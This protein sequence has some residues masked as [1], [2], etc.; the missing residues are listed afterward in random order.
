MTAG[1]RLLAICLFAWL[2]ALAWLAP[3]A[4]A[5]PPRPAE[6]SVVGG[7]GWHADNRFSLVWAPPPAVFPPILTARYRTRD[8]QGALLGEGSVSSDSNGAGVLV[9]PAVPGT[10]S[11]ELRFEDAAGELGP[12]ASVPL[13]FDHARPGAT[14]VGPVPA[15]VGRTALPLRVQL[16]HPTGPSPLSGIRGYAASVGPNPGGVPCPLSDVCSEQETTLHG[17][18]A[19]D[20]LTIPSLPEGTSY[21]HVVAVSGAG[22]KSLTTAGAVLHVDTA[23]PVTRLSGAPD[24]W[25]NR[26]V[27]LTASAVDAGA[28]MV[29]T[30]GGPQPLTAIRVDD[31]APTIAFGPAVTAS[32]IDEGAHLV[33]YYA[34]DAAGNTDDGGSAN[35]IVDNP[36]LTAWARVDRT[37][38]TLAFANSQDPD[39]PE[40]IRA[41]IADRLSGPNPTQGWIGV[42]LAGSGGRFEHLPAAEPAEGELR[43]RW[44]SD[45]WPVGS[46]EFEAVGFDAAGNV[47]TTTRRANGNAMVLTN[48]LKA[49]TRLRC[50]L[51]RGRLA[52][53]VPYGRGIRLRGRLT[54]GLSSGLA[55][56][57][58]RI[59]ER[60]AA[61]ATPAIRVSSVRTGPGGAISF[62]TAPGPSRTIEL[63][64]DGSR[65]LARSSAKPLSLLVRGRVR[66]RA[67]AG[68]A[69]VGGRPVIFS[70]R[71]VAP[72]GTVPAK[73][74]A[75]QLQFR[76]GRSPWSEF[77]S[78]ETDSRGRFHYPYRFSDDDSRGVSFQFRAYVPAHENWPYEPAGSRPV[79]V[80]GR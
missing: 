45:E 37:P 55:G 49:T 12:V 31:G 78:V 16:G 6:L 27:E 64:F 41:Q 20:V 58:L 7:N 46:Y 70:G 23:D 38:P 71:V 21:L 52:G 47:A 75:V 48:P 54:T 43:A 1:A 50:E 67:S 26:A 56:A 59:I 9:V 25:T 53:V 24:G 73:G 65:T 68:S 79:I 19:D 63:A 40:L 60:F 80:R 5:T 76:F 32:V 10:Y 29:A 44:R 18:V 8:P 13:R 42:R 17:G 2:I 69:K 36:P 30:G 66:L 11:A 4:A 14:A 33:R 22:V 35:G 57:M 61:G 39:D 34:R 3:L 28:G 77:R 62:R 15:W 51:A 74:L 72:A